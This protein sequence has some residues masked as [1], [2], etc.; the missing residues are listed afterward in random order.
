MRGRM[1]GSGDEAGP[2]GGPR[3][4]GRGQGVA[5]LHNHQDISALVSRAAL[6]AYIGHTGDGPQD[7]GDKVFQ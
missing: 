2:W 5:L 1:R 7:L 3:A 6:H 4:A